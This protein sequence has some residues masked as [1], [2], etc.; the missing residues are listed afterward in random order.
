MPHPRYKEP[1]KRRLLLYISLGGRAQYIANGGKLGRKVGYRISDDE[2]KE[3]YKNALALL[4]KGY[5]VRAESLTA[6]YHTVP[7]G[8]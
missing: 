3:K 6:V 5:S 2:L 8:G 1:L 7:A 4:K